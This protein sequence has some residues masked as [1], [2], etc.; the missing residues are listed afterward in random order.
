MATTGL[1]VEVRGPGF[2]LVYFPQLNGGS[3]VIRNRY[4]SAL[5]YEARVKEK[6]GWLQLESFRYQSVSIK[7]IDDLIKRRR[8]GCD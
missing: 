7:I 8:E 5:R 4:E 3:I 1:G 6:L 2:W